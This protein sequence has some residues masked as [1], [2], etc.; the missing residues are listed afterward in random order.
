LRIGGGQSQLEF[1]DVAHMQTKTLF[2]VKNPSRSA[3]VSH[4]IEQARRTT[5]LLFS[6]DDT[7]RKELAKVFRQ[8]YPR[9]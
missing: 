3:G 4:L 6:A 9:S 5:E 7:Y 2:F 8:S 1:C